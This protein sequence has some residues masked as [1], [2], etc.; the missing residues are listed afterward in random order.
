MASQ[1]SGLMAAMHGLCT[2]PPW[3]PGR[4]LLSTAARFS[5]RSA[6]TTTRPCFCPTGGLVGSLS[7]SHV[8][9][10]NIAA[11]DYQSAR[12]F[13]YGRSMRPSTLYSTM[14][15]CEDIVGI[16]HLVN[17][18]IL[19][20][21][22]IADAVCHMQAMSY[23]SGHHSTSD[24]SS[25]YRTAEEMQEW[26][27]RDPVTRFQAFLDEAGWWDPEK[28]KTLRVAVRKQV[29]LIA[30]CWIAVTA[31]TPVC[32]LTVRLRM[33]VAAPCRPCADHH[34]QFRTV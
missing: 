28:E 23:R 33:C 13:N 8:Y 6:Y 20:H 14:A 2:T 34:E 26:R 9:S 7:G 30:C 25:R 16:R 21:T 5:L 4:L 31:A 27:A 18:L 17:V 1:P 32:L 11:Q 24:D 12:L 10:G 19:A 29:G 15:W 22:V 3:R